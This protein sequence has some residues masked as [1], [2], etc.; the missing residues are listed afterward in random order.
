MKVSAASLNFGDIARCRGTVASVMGQVPFT[1]GM[2]V[3]GVVE[4]A[5]EG[6]EEWIGRR[7]VA[8]TIQ[9]FGGVADFAL[10]GV[11]G[12]FEAPPE[13]DDV[14]SGRVHAPVPH[15][16]PRGAAPGEAAGGRGAARDRRRQSAVGTAMIQLGTAAGAH[17]VAVAGGAREGRA[18]AS[19]RRRAD[20][21]PVRRP[22]R[23][24]DGPD[25]R[26][27]R[28]RVRRHDRRRGHRDDVDVHGPRGPLRRGRASTTTPSRDSPGARCARCRWATSR[29]IGVMMGYNDMPVEFRRFGLNT[30]PPAVGRE[31]HA[32]L[33]ELVERGEDQP[34]HR[35]GDRHGRGRR[36]A[37]RP[38]PS[39]HERPHGGRRRQ[40]MT[41]FEPEALLDAARAATGLDDFGPDELPRRARRAVRVARGA[42]R[43]STTSARSPS[44]AWWSAPCRT[45][46]ASSTGSPAIPRCRTSA[47]TRR[48]S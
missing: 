37:R 23:P 28:R 12:V 38:R 10:A 31:V 24:R 1:I 32:A 21:P 39:P 4:A 20:R 46:C 44:R 43:S 30:F 45:D 29:C 19:A 8:T 33:L 41:A 40:P 26:A 34:G 22:V 15:R 18:R 3:C 14:A 36:R 17:V 42:T 16:V 7:V 48:S 11:N 47:S 25:R 5:G 6:G 27:R 35:P 2:D 9:S 13:F